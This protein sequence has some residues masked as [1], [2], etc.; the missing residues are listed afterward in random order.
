M[1][2]DIIINFFF[3]FSPFLLKSFKLFF[4]N[5]VITGALII[6]PLQKWHHKSGCSHESL[7]AKHDPE[8]RSCFQKGWDNP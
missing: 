1:F 5:L 6:I 8:V 2:V 3:F 7:N 4:F